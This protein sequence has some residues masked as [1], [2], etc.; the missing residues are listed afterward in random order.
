VP[1]LQLGVLGP[2]HVAVEGRAVELRRPKQR[3]LL[4]L[5]L[6]NAGEVLSTDR[7]VEELW[8]GR[9]PKTALGSLQNLVSE[10]RKA[11]GPGILHTRPPGYVL[12]VDPELVDLHRFQR[13]VAEAV[14]EGDASRR[15]AQL[16]EALSLWRGPPLADLALEPFAQIEIARLDELRTSAREELIDAELELGLHSKLVAELDGLVAR[17][18]LRERLRGQLMLALYRSGR[19]AEALEAY[20]AAR[21]TLV[22]ELGIEPSEELQRLEQSILRHDAELELA[23]QRK[24]EARPE[25]VERRKTIS[26]LFAD[27]VDSTSLSARLDPEVVRSVMRRYY[28]TVRTIVERHGGTIEKFVGDAA[29]AVFGIP[30]LH[31]DDALRAVRAA[32][33]L[34]EALGPLNADLAR[35]H[36]LTIEIRAAVNTGEVI[37]ADAATGQQ[38]AAGGG[39]NVAMRL[40]QS[41]LPGEVLLGATTERLVR[42]AVTTEPVEAID[43]GGSIGRVDAFRLVTFAGEPAVRPVRAPFV[44]RADELAFLERAFARVLAE[45]R[46]EVITV[47][48][49]AGI[50]RS[51][52]RL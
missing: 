28:D 1:P 2:L 30:E 51:E 11:L 10:L 21:E 4:A 36:E 39:V 7:L 37:A 15:A 31:E 6:L 48:G 5:L 22:E 13:L 34:R 40:Q 17:H 9:P 41:A 43:L 12:A 29:M 3:S 42:E 32:E 8:G 50:G 35:E 27:I 45:R 46:S 18:P 24:A 14:E 16:R 49:D 19:Q 20:R 23:S 25:P 38:F 52:E 33:E 26:I 44:G 47:L